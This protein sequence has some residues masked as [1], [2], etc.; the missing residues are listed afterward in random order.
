MAKTSDFPSH[1]LELQNI[2]VHTLVMGGD[3]K[4][5]GVDEKKGSQI[6]FENIPNA[7]LA[8]FKDSFDP[9]SIM[10]KDIFNDMVLDFLEGH[11]LNSY[12]GVT[13]TYK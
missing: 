3:K 13:Y 10:K 4:I 7:V 2:S 6:I 9:L 8:L 12:E 5:M 11:K 1:T